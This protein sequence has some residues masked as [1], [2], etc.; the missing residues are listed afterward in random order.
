MARLHVEGD[1]LVVRLGVIDA[2]LS[3]RST[4]RFPLNSV[5]RAFSDPMAKDEPRGIKAPG[6]HVPRLLTM[7]TFHAEG[8]KSYW[9]V[10]TGES[11]VVV[12]LTGEKFDRL[13]IEQPDAD[14]VAEEILT[15]RDRSD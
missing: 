14:I 11:V 6:T 2:M 8:V 13:L 9:N 12:E 4:M 10:R 15:A 5:S 7:G 3:M 1:L